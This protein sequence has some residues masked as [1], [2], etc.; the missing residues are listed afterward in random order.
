[1][2]KQAV[3]LVGGLGTRLGALTEATPKP[4]LPVGGQPFL[5]RLLEEL[6][7]QGVSD[8]LLLAGYRAEQLMFLAES[9]PGVRVLIEPEPL[10][11]GGALRFA[12][13]HLDERFFFLNGDSLF[14]I[15]LWDLALAAGRSEACLALRP[16]PDVSRFGPALIKGDRIVH[17]AER[18][19]TSGP[20][21]INGGVG[22][23]T[24]Q[25]LKRIPAQGAVSIERDVY[26]RM[27][28]EGVLRGRVYDRPF[29][30]IGVPED[31]DRAQTA[32]PAMLTRGAVI[33][34][35]DGVLN[36]DVAYAHR[37]EQIEW[38]PGAIAAVKAVNDAGLFAFVATNQAGV[39]RGFY[40][41]DHVHDLHVWMNAVLRLHGA[42]IDAFAHSPYHPDG[43]VEAYARES[44]CRKPNPG[45]I[46]DLMGRFSV[47]QAKVV[48]IGDRDTDVAAAQAAGVRG[49]L[50][51]G[52]D[53]KAALAPELA[54]LSDD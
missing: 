37:P 29:I 6:L 42:Q 1:M 46:L 2:I 50:F 38:V 5:K 41:E 52:G 44:S 51:Q 21:L 24:R 28:Q 53:L 49:V 25:V 47:N 10:G 14:D 16:V 19:T 45:M 43:V 20:G 39:A 3:V 48:M 23:L 8:I 18:P 9:L 4:L 17:F 11:T 54:R 26:P 27:A 36:H 12:A 32:V 34:D 13:D 7:R 35:R 33:F 40:G 31:F 22:V 30:D 15:N